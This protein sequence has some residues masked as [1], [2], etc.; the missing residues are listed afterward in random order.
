LS[1]AILHLQEGAG[2]GKEEWS[3]FG[4]PEGMSAT[5]SFCEMEIMCKR[6]PPCFA[7]SCQLLWLYLRPVILTGFLVAATPW[8]ICV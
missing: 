5:L 6:Q 1:S 4:E 8:G 7:H 3:V 2:M